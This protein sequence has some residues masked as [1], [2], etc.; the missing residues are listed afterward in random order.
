MSIQ[1]AVD[2]TNPGQFLGCCGLLEFAAR[3][4]PEVAVEGW[5]ADNDRRFHMSGTGSLTELVQKIVDAEVKLLDEGDIYSGRIT[6]GI[7]SPPLVLD[8]WHETGG[9]RDAKDLKV[10]AGT[11]ESHGIAR[12]MQQAMRGEPFRS[13]DL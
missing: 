6:V 11:M 1:V 3:I 2:P 5:F 13:P 12:A 8:W 10:W 7:G 9:R 4:W